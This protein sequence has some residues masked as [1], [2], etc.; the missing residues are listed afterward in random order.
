LRA[1]ELKLVEIYTD[2]GCIPNPGPGG[3][4]AVLLYNNKIREL[5]GYEPET[6]NNRMELLAA[7]KAMEAL[8]MPCRVKLYSDSALLIN[9]FNQNWVRT[10]Q[11]KNWIKTGNEPVKNPD[12]WKRLLELGQIHQIEWIKVKGHAGIQYNERCDQLATAAIRQARA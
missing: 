5:S 6:T 9:A 1:I 4:G 10:W 8:K 2:G 3:W 11:R 12:L 7:I